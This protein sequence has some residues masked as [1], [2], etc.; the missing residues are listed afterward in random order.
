MSKRLLVLMCS[1]FLIVPLL[2]MGC[3]GDDGAQ[4]PAGDN[5]SAGGPGT[6]VVALETCAACHGASQP[7]D[8]NNMHRLNP[9]TGNPVPAGTALVTVN[10]VTFGAPVGD[11]VPV[12]VA[13]TFAA[14]DKAGANITPQIDLTTQGTGTS[15]G[16]LA[17]LRFTLAKM[18]PG[19]NG[20][21]NEWSVFIHKPGTTGSGPF[22]ENRLTGGGAI[23]GTVA[24]GVYT[25]TFPD[26][27]VRV[28]DGYVDN[29]VVRTIVEARSLPLNLFVS[30]PSDLIYY[31]PTA[32][33]PVDADELDTFI[34]VGGGAGVPLVLG[35]GNPRKNDVSTAACNACHDPLAIHGGSRR[36]YKYC[37]TC[38]NAKLETLSTLESNGTLVPNDNLNLVN[39]VHKIHNHA[40]GVQNI[41]FND[42]S[43]VTYPQDIRNCTRCHQGTEADNTYANWMNKPTRTAC[44]SCHINVNFDTGVGH[45]GGAQATNAICTLCH[46]PADIPRNH[47]TENTTPN[48]KF[49]AG[50]LVNLAYEIFSV[51]V[52]NTNTATIR[53]SIKT[54]PDNVLLNLGDNVITRPAIFNAPSQ[55]SF[56]FAY[57]LPQDG[58]AAPVDYNNRGRTA[59]QPESLNILGL[60]ITAK[61][62]TSYTVRRADAFPVGATMRA[63]ALQGYF[64]Q[65]N[66]ADTNGDGALDNV[67]RHTYSAF[68][69][70]NGDA[71]RRVAV[72]SG[73]TNNNQ[74]TG[75]PTGCLECHEIFEGHGGNRVSNAQV[76]VMCHNPNLSSSGRTIDPA[77]LTSPTASATAKA[78][79]AGY[80]T[81]P[82]VY[83]EVSN[84]FKELIHGIHGAA[85]R[86]TN[87]VDIRG[88]RLALIEGDEITYPGDLSHCGKCHFTNLYQNVQTTGRLNSTVKTT[89]GVATETR[90]QIIAARASVPNATDLVN[91][92]AT[93]ACGHCHDSD[94]ARS[95][96]VAM[97]GE[98][99][100]PRSTAV[101]VPPPL[102]P[103]VLATP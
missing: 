51:T 76:C 1:I 86:T 60:A 19:L 61:D 101:L 22:T 8:V 95:H 24:T 33:K 47:A 78:I 81:N 48:N 89:T 29:V 58:I 52:D 43:E 70:V 103:D 41:V 42:F 9:T 3:S 49:V 55:P 14:T 69:S 77:V 6:G 67:A 10:S 62:N 15:A 53:F 96:F 66:G 46:A 99:R 102:Y 2:F 63:V 5:G 92:P 100:A 80:G 11:N 17:Y 73:Y 88:D 68:R 21:A 82:L 85:K 30:D 27:S 26:N 16:T 74:L 56:L 13:F 31:N 44:G 20:N 97:G 50:T 39:L 12:S 18:V 28:S 25:Y 94:V 91:T 65:T 54:I 32:R 87:F 93:S 38:H 59:G 90:D 35:D 7:F 57:A 4:G 75:T 34:P 36:D 83:P 37:S 23:A 79:V 71:V 84:N 40:P 45:V 98:I 64:T 72:E